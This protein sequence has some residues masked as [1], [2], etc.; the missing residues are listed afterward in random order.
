[1]QTGLSSLKTAVE[2]SKNRGSFS[3]GRLDYL[4]WKDGDVHVV[5]FLTDDVVTAKFHEFTI[6]ASGGLA[7]FIIDDEKGDLVPKYATES[8]ETGGGVGWRRDFKTKQP[9]DRKPRELTVGIAVVRD[10]VPRDGGGFDVEDIVAEQDVDGTNFPA[11]SF[12]LIQQSTS[13]FWKQMIGFVDLY[14]TICDRDYRIRRLGKGI[15]TEYAITPLDKDEA[16]V[17]PEKVRKFYGYGKKWDDEDPD[18][19]LFCPETMPQWVERFSSE[20]RVKYFLAPG[21]RDS[22][23]AK[24]K[25]EPA[26]KQEAEPADE[27]QAAA[28][29]ASVAPVSGTNFASLRE[30]LLAGK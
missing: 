6:T 24:N 7:T 26:P 3:G 19:F 27:A 16:L 20:D 12:V 25:K 29:V 28:P 9:A 17:D 8:P 1:M 10:L 15:D 18:R 2:N 21:D 4:S 5:R 22:A 14:G 30:K 11:R 23:P 13:N